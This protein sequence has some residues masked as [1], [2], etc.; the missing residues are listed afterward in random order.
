MTRARRRIPRLAL[1]AAVSGVLTLSGCKTLMPPTL[2]VVTFNI[3]HGGGAAG[4]WPGLPVETYQANVDAVAEVVRHE[5]PDV[6]AVQE[7]DAPSMW[8]GS[9]DHV[10]RLADHAGLPHVH[11]GIHFDMGVG[12][13]RIT[14]GTA[15]VGRRP[16]NRPASYRSNV[17]QLHTK[18]FV[19][20][21]V[22]LAGRPLIVTSIHLESMSA[23]TRRREVEQIIKLLEESHRPVVLMGDLNSQWSQAD[24]AVRILASRL[25]LRAY[26]PEQPGLDTFSAR[27]P[28]R[29][30]DWILLSKELAFTE[31]RVV[32]AK[33]SDHLGVFASVRWK[34]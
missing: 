5:N 20:A 19:T 34:E 2:R 23:S 32:P 13:Y 4:A 28:R 8:S 9:L 10:R 11:H 12:T 24:D 25:H 6:L 27:N 3:A 22:T 29:R 17:H 14:Y 31:Y 18:G 33:V 30:I 21:E 15:L 1:S 7:A 16:L 26:E